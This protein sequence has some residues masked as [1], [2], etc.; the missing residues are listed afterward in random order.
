METLYVNMVT[1][2]GLSVSVPCTADSLL[3]TV[4]R[5]GRRGWYCDV[6]IPE[7]GFKFPFDNEYDFDWSILGARLFTNESGETC[8]YCRGRVWKRRE[9]PAT[10]TK[11]YT[12]PETIKY[13]R[14]A[15]PSDP[16]HVREP[17][18]G[19]IEYVTLVRFMGGKRR[20]ELALEPTAPVAAANEPCPPRDADDGEMVTPDDASAFFKEMVANGIRPQDLHPFVR[21]V[22]GRDVRELTKLTKRELARLRQAA[23][24][25][26]QPGRASPAR[27]LQGGRIDE[28]DAP[29]AEEAFG[30]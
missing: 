25:S 15:K 2:L 1:D 6:P 19:E 18:D 5:Y 23:L 29:T 20:E 16:P 14:G 3:E 4:K 7:R 11:H 28:R 24:A 26:R 13:S 30:R 22:C 17:S 21:Q 12:Y 27:G 9:V 8:V 10:T